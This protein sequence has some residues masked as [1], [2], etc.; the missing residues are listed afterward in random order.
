MT[1]KLLSIL[2]VFLSA[3]SIRVSAEESQDSVT[4]KPHNIIDRVIDYFNRSND[5]QSDKPFDVS[6]IGGPHYSSDTKFG[7]GAV[8]A[9]VYRHDRTDSL[10]RQSN[11]SLYFDATTSLFFMVGIRGTHFF[12]GN[13]RRISYNVNFQSVS[14]YFWGIGYDA[15]ANNANKSKY[16]YLTSNVGVEYIWRTLPDLYIGPRVTF[17]YVNGHDFARPELIDDRKRRTFSVGA[18]LTV[19]FDT[20]DNITATTHGTYVKIDQIFHPEWIGNRQPFTLTEVSASTFHPLWRDAILAANLHSRLSYGDT[21][22]GLLSTFGGSSNMRGY[23]EGRYRDKN[24]IDICVELRQHIWRRNGAVVWIG[25]GTVFPRFSDL[26]SR[27][28]LP[29]YGIGYRWEFKHLINVRLDYGFGRGESGFIF[30][31]N[32]AF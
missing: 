26:R 2:F 20:R 15:G 3:I 8:A 22:W 23:F 5:V 4:E 24:E 14:S 1:K 18:G 32:E 16:N 6:F 31:I 28:L 17:N 25:G 7:L 11:V 12:P 13:A 10:C 19:Q 9:G 30:S 27:H 29:N 21:P